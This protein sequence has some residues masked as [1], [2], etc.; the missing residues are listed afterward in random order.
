M[1]IT[2]TS[3]LYK[4]VMDLILLCVFTHNCISTI[5][6]VVVIREQGGGL[7]EEEKKFESKF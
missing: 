2:S 7:Q 5:R 4:G 6:S 3:S 1:P